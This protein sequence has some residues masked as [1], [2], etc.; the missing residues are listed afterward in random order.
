MS[1]VQNRN[2]LSGGF[3]LIEMMIVVAIIG[4]LTMVALPAYSKYVQ[5]ARRADAQQYIMDKVGSLERIYT[6][7]GG[8]P[9]TFTIDATDYYTFS[10]SV[11]GTTEFSISA[12]PAGSQTSDRCGTITITHQGTTSP[13]GCW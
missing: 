11:T 2:G 7:R 4:I 13:S 6:R 8:Y 5:D 10:Y 3:T 12:A 9:D 1:S